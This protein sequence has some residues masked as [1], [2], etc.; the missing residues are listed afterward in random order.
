MGPEETRMEK[1]KRSPA[2][3]T[4]RPEKMPVVIRNAP[5]GHNWGWYSRE[6]PRMHLQSVDAEHNYKV[7]L[8]DKGKR[9]F[10][11][12]GSIPGKVVKSL[13]S[14]V[15]DR[16]QFLEDL[17]VRLMLDHGW[18]DLHVALPQLTLV[19]YPKLTGNFVR[20]IDL[21]EWFSPQQLTTLQPE[22]ITLNRELAALRLWTD[23]SE[24]QTPY[25]VRLSTLLWRE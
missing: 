13:K 16:R 11:P 19:A 3:L 18:L 14:A 9:I 8:E 15:A 4:R 25:D 1:T 17:W 5:P 2:K 23:R 20:K 22:I 21:R 6:D 24:E 12:V 10:Q 7:W